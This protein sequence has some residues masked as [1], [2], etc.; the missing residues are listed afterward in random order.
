MLR[1]PFVDS[2]PNNSTGDD[3]ALFSV[4]NQLPTSLDCSWD[5]F[6]EYPAF[7]DINADYGCDFLQEDSLSLHPFYQYSLEDQ[8][9][10]LPTQHSST[11]ASVTTRTPTGQGSTSEQHETPGTAFSEV[12]S[13][14]PSLSV[15]AQRFPCTRC[16]T[17]CTTAEEL[18]EHIE[19][20]HPQGSLR[21][22][23]CGTCEP[24][25]QFKNQKDFRRHLTTT[26]AHQAGLITCRCERR[27]RKDKFRLHIQASLCPATVLYRCPC[28]APE[29][30]QSPSA[31]TAFL[32]HLSQCGRRALGRPRGKPSRH[33]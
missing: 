4:Q 18:L 8:V 17:S 1:S 5:D 27:F 20:Q 28:N 15:G 21:S 31:T 26:K 11:S 9:A 33:H 16:S 29:G 2:E 12:V 10:A 25:K 7:A 6:P 19:A 3:E 23:S 14:D 30:V 13:P 32:A 24:L 22:Y